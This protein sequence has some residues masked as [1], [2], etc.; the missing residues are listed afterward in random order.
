MPAIIDAGETVACHACGLE[1]ARYWA[2][3]FHSAGWHLVTHRAPCGQ[4]C[5]GAGLRASESEL[6][7]RERLDT[8]HYSDSRCP[9][10][11]SE[12]SS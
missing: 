10:C 8:A 11:N 2:A 3:G 9:V 6:P 5:F 4:E 1:V 12:P 7:M